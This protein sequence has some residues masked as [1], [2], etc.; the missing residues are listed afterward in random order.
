MGVTHV[1]Q[2]RQQVPQLVRV[3]FVAYTDGSADQ[4]HV[5][6]APVNEFHIDEVCVRY[7]N[8]RP[9]ERSDLSRSHPNG[10]DRAIVG[11]EGAVVPPA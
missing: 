3:G 5:A 4:H 1:A 6:L 2:V 10:L 11:S 7:G 9:V 8:E